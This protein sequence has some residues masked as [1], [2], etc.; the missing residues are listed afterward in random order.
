[1]TIPQTEKWAKEIREQADMITAVQ[2]YHRLCDCFVQDVWL[3]V[4][5]PEK[6]FELKTK[7]AI[8]FNLQ[9]HF[10]K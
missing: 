8:M 5:N 1:M 6:R 2:Q 4:E 10:C 9:S 7:S 3:D